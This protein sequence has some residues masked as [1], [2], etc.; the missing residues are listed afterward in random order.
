MNVR[1]VAY[2]VITYKD[3][4]LFKLDKDSYYIFD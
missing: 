3:E 4:T 2:G 1:K